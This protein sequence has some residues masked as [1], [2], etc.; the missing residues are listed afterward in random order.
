MRN[1]DIFNTD[2]VDGKNCCNGCDSAGF[3]EQV[4]VND[5]FFLCRSIGRI[6]HGIPVFAGTL[7]HIVELVAFFVVNQVFC[8]DEKADIGIQHIRELLLV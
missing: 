7:K 5:V 3:I 8:L 6:F 4:A 2:L 1:A